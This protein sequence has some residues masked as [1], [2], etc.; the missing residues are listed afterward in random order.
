MG[1]APPN[2]PSLSA[3]ALLRYFLLAGFFEGLLALLVLFIIPG[4]AKNAWL[5][6]LS[7]ARFA[8]AG[9]LLLVTLF[10]GWLFRR[11]SRKAEWAD[12]LAARMSRHVDTL[13]W[14]VPAILTGYWLVIYAAYFYLLL[15]HANLTTLNS[16][17][18]RLAP[19]FLLGL[20]RLLQMTGISARWLLQRAPAAPSQQPA[21]GLSARTAGLM[22]AGIALLLILA[23]VSLDV[24]EHL[25]W[26]QKFL[27]YRVKFDLDQEANIPTFFA[28][29]NLAL[30]AAIFA[31]TAA[32]KRARRDPF[33]RHWA[34]LGI[35][36]LAL[37]V[38]ETAVLH[39]KLIDPLHLA[40]HTRGAF[41]FAWV[42][43][44]IPLVVIF[45]IA[46]RRFFL[47]LPRRAKLGF[48]LGFA[49]YITGALGFELLGGFYADL[50]RED[51]PI[52]NLITTLE[53]TIEMS[54]VITL[55]TAA[56][57]YLANHLPETRLIV[58]K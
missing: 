31:V 51:T 26:E 53:E 44:A 6:G 32:G 27:G 22:L 49:L 50:I 52:Y 12:R 15:A 47:H 2:S 39:E 48:A 35:V 20:T 13:G 29:F 18:I 28:T 17:L 21:V 38:D 33:T 42:L 54:G 56:L 40:F 43:P 36:F 3:T 24:I 46:V 1:T 58:G 55:I 14:Y 34:F 4:D 57:D 8:L 41:L 10:F 23:S 45:L 11:A 25:T 16:I 5:F 19:F 7:K 37:A 30:L 9:I